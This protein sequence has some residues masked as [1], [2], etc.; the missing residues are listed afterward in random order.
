MIKTPPT[1][2]TCPRIPQW[3]GLLY[4]NTPVIA[5]INGLLAAEPHM[6]WLALLHGTRSSDGREVQVH[7]LR[8]PAQTRTYTRCALV[9]H[10]LL[11]PDLV[12]VLHSHHAMGAWFSETDHI[13]LNPR[14]PVSVVVSTQQ[15]CAIDR[16]LGFS[17]YIHGTVVLPCGSLGT[18]EF[19]LR[20][21]PCPRGWPNVPEVAV[22]DTV[23]TFGDCPH[24][25]EAS[26]GEPPLPLY[27]DRRAVC[28]LV[29]REPLTHVFGD[30]DALV[31]VLRDQTHVPVTESPQ[32]DSHSPWFSNRDEW[33]HDVARGAP[34]RS[35]HDARVD[36]SE[37]MV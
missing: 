8:I 30:D 23:A 5:Q 2:K 6:E 33:D 21:R 17:A 26:T 35:W 25:V 16:L 19:D 34:Q 1:I 14:F 4:L 37:W 12:G 15:N 7:E 22:S 9:H 20:P 11:T 18:C 27:R 28:G 10:E 13:T 24:T 31:S 3:R 32:P 29:C 36:G